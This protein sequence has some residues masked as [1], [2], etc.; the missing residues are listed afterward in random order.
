MHFFRDEIGDCMEKAYS[1]IAIAEAAKLLLYEGTNN[2]SYVVEYAKT[3]CLPIFQLIESVQLEINTIFCFV[4]V[5]S[6]QM[7]CERQPVND[8]V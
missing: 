7:E 3:V 8:R 5:V 4:V 6:A 2:L 1:E